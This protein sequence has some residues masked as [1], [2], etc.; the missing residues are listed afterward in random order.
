MEGRTADRPYP[1]IMTSERRRT[2]PDLQREIDDALEGVDLQTLSE[3]EP[4]RHGERLYPGVIAGVHDD[5]VIVELGPR[6]QGVCSLREFD[7]PPEAGSRF[8]F[9]LRGREDDLWLLSRRGAV[10]IA[11]WNELE[12]GSA[13]K[14]RVS[15]VNQGGLQLK[16]G[17]HDAFMP[18]SQV[19]LDREED[20]SGWI[21]QTVTALVLEVDR[22]R[23][24][25]VLSRRRLLERERETARAE[26]AEGLVPGSVVSGKVTRLE[27]F[28]A[29]VDIGA[30]V[31][32]L[33]HVS[34]L[35]RRRVENASDV[36]QKGQDVRVMVLEVRDGGKRIGLGM[37]QLEPDPWE[38]VDRRYGVDTVCTGKVT[39]LMDFGAFVELEP[40]LEGLLH[41]SQLGRDRVRRAADVLSVGEELPVRVI[42]VE[43]ARERLSLSRL[44]PRG[45][46]L[47][48]E[49]AVDADVIDAVLEQSSTQQA[50]GTNLGSLF[51]KALGDRP[52]P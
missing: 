5:D 3:R 7:E 39:R 31:E 6:M 42:A 48:S 14:A 47:G 50:L 45:A 28:G 30:G 18:A 10:E 37:K 44:D 12:P 34:N 21:G 32:G 15:G 23:K 11:T 36:L 46:L 1:E 19:S 51:K 8:E 33:V 26:T 27:T 49:E 40:G 38:D 22:S 52:R 4:D 41:V 2:D 16:I 25:V 9:T 13:V 24:R 43:R 35:S 29:F 17:S 20:L